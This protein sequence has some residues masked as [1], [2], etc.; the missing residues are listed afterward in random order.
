MNANGF[1]DFAAFW[2]FFNPFEDKD[3]ED[4]GIIKCPNCGRQFGKDDK[5][6][7]VNVQDKVFK[8]PGCSKKLRFDSESEELIE[9]EEGLRIGKNE[10]WQE[11]DQANLKN[12]IEF[13]IES[14]NSANE[15]IRNNA[16][17]D[18][19][20]IGEAAIKPLVR[21]LKEKEEF[22]KIAINWILAKIGGPVIDDTIPLLKDKDSSVRLCA[23]DIL[24]KIKDIKAIEPL[25]ETFKED[26]DDRVRWGAL[27]AL[28]E[29]NPANLDLFIQAAKDSC[30]RIREAAAKPL[31]KSQNSKA[32]EPLIELLKDKHTAVRSNALSVWH[33]SKWL[34][35]NRV[36]EPLI[37]FLKEEN[38]T[39]REAAAA[40][41]GRLNDPKAVEPL[42]DLLNDKNWQVKETALFALGN[43]KDKKA[44]E[45][46]L[47]IAVED[48][49]YRIRE[50]AFRMLG[51]IKDHSVIGKL[52]MIYEEEGNDFVERS[53]SAALYEL[54]KKDEVIDKEDKKY[55]S[56]KEFSSKKAKEITF[57]LSR[58]KNGKALSPEDFY[59]EIK[60]FFYEKVL[61]IIKEKSGILQ[62]ELYK[63]GF[64]SSA[65]YWAARAGFIKR[66][67]SSNSFKLFPADTIP[68]KEE[69]LKLIFLASERI[70]T[71]IPIEAHRDSKKRIINY[72]GRDL[73]KTLFERSVWGLMSQNYN[74]RFGDVEEK[75][76]N[77]G[78][79]VIHEQN[80]EQ[81]YLYS[82]KENNCY[83][84]IFLA[85]IG[86]CLDFEMNNSL[87]EV[88]NKYWT[89]ECDEKLRKFYL[90]YGFFSS[91]Y[92][93]NSELVKI[94]GE[95]R[96][97]DFN[98]EL[99]KKAQTFKIKWCGFHW[100]HIY[101]RHI[102]WDYTQYLRFKWGLRPE[103]Y[104]KK[105]I[106]CNNSFYPLD[107]DFSF[108]EIIQY[109]PINESIK[110]VNFCP[111]HFPPSSYGKFLIDNSD[112]VSV[113]ERMAKL[114]K[115]LTDTLEF[116]PPSNFHSRLNYLKDIPKEKFEE[117]IKIINDMPSFEKTSST[118]PRGYKDIFGSWLKALDTAGILEGG[119]RKTSRG[120]IC[121]AKDGHECRS[122]G[123]KIIDD[124]LFIHNIPHE[125]EPHYPGERQFRADWKVG[126]YFIE[127]WGLKGDEDY[128]KKMEDKKLVAQQHQIPLIE[129]TFDDLRHLELKFKDI[130][131]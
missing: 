12:K 35:D 61:P 100:D 104:E 72:F 98:T 2:E 44:T 117:A 123:E 4:K 129:I 121:L 120:Y 87:V 122:I 65:F 43:L 131:V 81:V 17:N 24:K 77:A 33:F 101:S 108:S 55:E 20:N 1:W 110:E 6:E 97:A 105:C 57:T 95:R 59:E 83:V 76:V 29:I 53:I 115:K 130:I 11:K 19:S 125:Q 22:V 52:K 111:K 45:P 113:K 34:N 102:I 14:L 90:K 28:G 49:D 78:W 38:W 84:N 50:N 103:L 40:T 128:D 112:D 27:I 99:E 106:Y 18:L 62:R 9:F 68:S 82:R 39:D 58:E 42:L 54:E 116:I 67:K 10:S 23:T 21:A 124:Y 73:L 30:W 47:K 75:F 74:M 5:I 71:P 94:L 64:D 66:E 25:L 85:N 86:S 109:F 93:A 56:I 46:I 88:I 31:E 8:C 69:A 114:L 26:R 70:K 3:K 91:L 96:L 119:V 32:V 36:V 51:K 15:A 63:D 7:M 127:F 37:T 48:K 79:Q 92:F 80:E 41:L 126:S 13:L 107:P 118:E 16:A 89:K 60:K